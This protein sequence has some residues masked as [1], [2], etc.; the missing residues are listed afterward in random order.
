MHTISL[1]VP[2]LLGII[3]V[4]MEL[5]APVGIGLQRC[6]VAE[7]PPNCDETPIVECIRG[8]SKSKN[9]HIFLAVYLVAPAYAGI[10]I[11]T[12]L[13]YW[14]ARQQLRQS[15]QYHQNRNNSM[16][17]ITVQSLAYGTLFVHYFMWP[18]ILP[19]IQKTVSHKPVEEFVHILYP[20]GVISSV[21]FPLQGFFNML[22]FARPRF[23]RIRK[24]CGDRPLWWVLK[25]TIV[26][27]PLR[28][29][30]HRP[31]GLEPRIGKKVVVPSS[32]VVPASSG[33][34]KDEVDC[35]STSVPSESSEGDEA[36]GFTFATSNAASSLDFTST[37]AKDDSVSLG[38]GLHNIQVSDLSHPCAHANETESSSS[39][40]QDT[41]SGTSDQDTIIYHAQF[42]CSPREP[43][44]RDEPV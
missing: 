17:E 18:C 38:V 13:V 2:I 39:S 30:F 9:L 16:R 6:F 3:G 32:G 25:E 43:C 8:S 35:S 40:Q 19:A 36:S 31:S 24:C 26:G 27:L 29:Y 12:I 20:L 15:F 42:L 7:F 22:I 41:A 44:L 23:L 14:T 5:Y 33:A 11:L 4:A 10:T 37:S 1:G 21:V 28:E 34:S